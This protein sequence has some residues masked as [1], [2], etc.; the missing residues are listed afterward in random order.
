[1]MQVKDNGVE[2]D[3]AKESTV[4]SDDKDAEMD[5]DNDIEDIKK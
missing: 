4:D 5:S 3:E 2:K 1:M